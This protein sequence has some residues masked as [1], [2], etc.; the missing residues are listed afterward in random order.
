[1]H[2]PRSPPGR[3]GPLELGA[4]QGQSLLRYVN[5]QEKLRVGL[6]RLRSLH[7]RGKLSLCGYCHPRQ[8]SL[9]NQPE[10]PQPHHFLAIPTLPHCDPL[11][12]ARDHPA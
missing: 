7:P 10:L 9:A 3:P 4:K 11:A 5:K 6:Q 12:R 1:M 8:I 2:W